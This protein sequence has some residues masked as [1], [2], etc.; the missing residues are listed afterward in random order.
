MTFTVNTLT[1]CVGQSHYTINLTF[2][3]GPTVNFQT[4]LD[5][6]SFDPA[7]DLEETRQEILDRLRSAVK[8]ANANNFAQARTALEGK[9]FKV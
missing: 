6:M 5:E 3:S 4:T 2:A 1:R 9:T 8:E 7:A